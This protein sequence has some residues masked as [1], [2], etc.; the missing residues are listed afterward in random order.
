M[1]VLLR[2]TAQGAQV[3]LIERA[4]RDGDPWS[5]NMAFPGGRVDGSD[6]DSASYAACRETREEIGIEIDRG[7]G[8]GRLSDQIT[9]D[10]RRR[11]LMVI[12]PFVYRCPDHSQLVYNHE[13]ADSEWVTLAWLAEHGHR[14]PHEWA[15]G[16]LKLSMPSYALSR[17]R[18]LWGLTLH[19]LDELL[20]IARRR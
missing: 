8:I 6:E 10:H 13:I 18:R 14:Q 1:A 16:P 9:L 12:S 5:G 7:D 15:V 11:G 4:H 19:M 17:N 2:E 20:R 3:L